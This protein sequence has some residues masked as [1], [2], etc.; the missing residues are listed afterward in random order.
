MIA[1]VLLCAGCGD[2]S[3]DVTTTRPAV[4]ADAA[5]TVTGWLAA[6]ESS[7][8]ALLAELVDQHSLVVIMA[9]ENGFD[10][11]ETTALLRD[12]IPAELASEYW[13]SF[14]DLFFAFSRR[15]LGSLTVG[16]PDG[17]I[18]GASGVIAVVPLSGA[19]DPASIVTRFDG[20]RWQIDMV[21][22]F[23]RA[24]APALH[25]AYRE[26]PMGDEGQE[27]RTAYQLSVAGPLT[28]ALE[29]MEEDDDSA[30]AIRAL[31]ADISADAAVSVP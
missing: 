30:V 31:L 14:G 24:L 3:T 12:G 26:I 25:E 17:A 28:D 9:L 7:D 10:A 13:G 5:A 2:D 23:G 11:A 6:V 18:D 4:P 19:A 27:V 22:T 29:R 16:V 20:A 21:G 15:P 1:F 8:A